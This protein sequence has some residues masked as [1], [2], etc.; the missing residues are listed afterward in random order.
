MN[1]RE[2]ARHFCTPLEHSAAVQDFALALEA[3]QGKVR[4]SKRT[5]NLFRERKAGQI[6]L[7]ASSFSRTLH[8]DPERGYAEVQG[9]CTFED[10]TNACLAFN[11][12]PAVIPELKTITVGGAVSGVGIEATSFRHGLMHETVEQMEV[13]CGDGEVRVCRSD[14]EYADLFRAIPNSYGTLGYILSLRCRIVPARLSVQ[15]TYTR[16]SDRGAFLS[17]MKRACEMGAEIP[18]VDFIEGVC[19]GPSNFVLVSAVHGDTQPDTTNTGPQPYYKGLGWKTSATLSTLDWV[20]RWDPDWFWCSRFYGM[21]NPL[22]RS[23]ARLWMMRSDRYWKVRS[24]YLRNKLEDKI[25]RLRRFFDW[26][27]QL[28]E[29]VIQDVEIP[30][31]RCGE[32]LD[33]YRKHIG[34]L[35]LWI[36]PIRPSTDANRWTLY[37]MPPG[38]LHLN[39][40][41][42]E[43]VPTT[44]ENPPNHFNRLLEQEVVRLGGRKSLYSVCCFPEDEFWQ[45]YNGGAY[46]SLKERY[47]PNHRFPN[48]YQ[49]AVQ[50][51]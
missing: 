11:C 15:A 44:A 7:D 18:A 47:D 43:S 14:N 34:I 21:E 32:F 3:T 5:S 30:I 31:S 45:I 37:S 2:H 20:W 26:P 39:F 10:F 49:K 42:W 17:A 19:F 36:C 35:P 9:M 29:S 4:L 50:R 48:L 51:R 46:R 38:E 16:F 28:R 25:N 23:L 6:P 1:S 40:G 33:F 8:V 41:F 13:L 12:L 22:I 27:V 24:W